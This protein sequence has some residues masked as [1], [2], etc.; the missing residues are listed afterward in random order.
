MHVDDDEN[1]FICCCR[2]FAEM[3]RNFKIFLIST[4]ITVD[5]NQDICLSVVKANGRVVAQFLHKVQGVDFDLDEKK[6]DLLRK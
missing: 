6:C 5:S 1:C 2:N 3:K 4:N